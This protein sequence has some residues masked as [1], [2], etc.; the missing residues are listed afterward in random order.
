MEPNETPAEEKRINPRTLINKQVLRRLVSGKKK[1]MGADYVAYLNKKL[2]T[3]VLGHIHMLGSRATLK[4][5]DFI[6]LDA[7]NKRG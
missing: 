2:E 7:V 4:A 6:F 1:R 5:K 3:I